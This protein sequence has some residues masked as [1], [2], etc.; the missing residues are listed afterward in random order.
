MIVINHDFS[1]KTLNG[2]KT[3]CLRFDKIAQSVKR[4]IKDVLKISCED[5][6]DTSARY[7]LGV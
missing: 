4:H 6:Q 1:Y 3:L 5:N 2:T 7:L